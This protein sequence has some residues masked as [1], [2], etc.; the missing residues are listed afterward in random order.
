MRAVAVLV[1][2]L[3]TLAAVPTVSALYLRPDLEKIPVQ[4][5]IDNLEFDGG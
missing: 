1:G 3:L 2:L 4:R 5:L